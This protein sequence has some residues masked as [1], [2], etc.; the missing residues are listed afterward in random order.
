MAFQFHSISPRGKMSDIAIHLYKLISENTIEKVADFFFGLS[1]C[2][3][4]NSPPLLFEKKM[5]L[6]ETF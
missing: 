4:K 3:I 5:T 1:I 6:R 2:N